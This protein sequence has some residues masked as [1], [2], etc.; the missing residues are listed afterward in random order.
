VQFNIPPVAQAARTPSPAVIVALPGFAFQAAVAGSRFSG[1]HARGSVGRALCFPAPAQTLEAPLPC[2]GAFLRQKQPITNDKTK[3]A[4]TVPVFSVMLRPAEHRPS[5]QLSRLRWVA[6]VER[7]FRINAR[8]QKTT[9][10]LSQT[11]AANGASPI[12]GDSPRF[13]LFRSHFRPYSRVQ[14]LV[15]AR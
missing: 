4:R 10:T 2:A 9:D 5:V 11:R 6:V 8:R 14:R 3:V 13:Y 15:G 7:F 1:L 12:D